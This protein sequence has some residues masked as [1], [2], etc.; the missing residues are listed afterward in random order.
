LNINYD[1]GTPATTAKYKAFNALLKNAIITNTS[2]ALSAAGNAPTLAT[3]RQLRYLLD[4]SKQ[5]PSDL[6]IIT[7]PEVEAKLLGIDEFLTMDKAGVHATNMTGQM[8]SIDG[9]PVFITNEIATAD[10]DGKIT[11]D[12]NVAETGR[13]MIVHKNSWYV[14]YR[15]RMVLDFTYYPALDAY[16]LSGFVRLAFIGQDADSVAV[17]YNIGI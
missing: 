1:G 17:M 11:Y 7:H 10:T 4:R 16:A 8:G 6:A 9:I 13:L 12:G 15:R 14:G 5:R 2:N 3:I